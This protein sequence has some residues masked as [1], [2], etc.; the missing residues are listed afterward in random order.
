[1]RKIG[2]EA[3]LIEKLPS[4]GP[5]KDYIENDQFGVH[6]QQSFEEQRI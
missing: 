3:K 6:D 5:L 1:M 4:A 2:A